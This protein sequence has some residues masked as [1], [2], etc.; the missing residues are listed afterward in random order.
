MQVVCEMPDDSVAIA[1]RAWRSDG[2]DS[3]ADDEQ[4]DAAAVAVICRQ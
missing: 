1:V 4:H 3:A 2:L